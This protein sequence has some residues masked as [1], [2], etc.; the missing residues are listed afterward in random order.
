MYCPMKFNIYTL[1]INGNVAD[2]KG[3]Q[4]DFEECAC[5]DRE[6]KACGLRIK[7]VNSTGRE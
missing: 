5:Y 1:D 7:N 4:C 3:C 6:E 2:K